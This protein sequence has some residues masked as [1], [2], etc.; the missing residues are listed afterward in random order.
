MNSKTTKSVTGNIITGVLVLGVITLG[1][2]T[3]KQDAAVPP[4]DTT[5]QG[6]DTALSDTSSAPL[7]TSLRVAQTAKDLRDLSTSVANSSSLFNRPVFRSLKDFSV[8]ISSEPAGRENPFVKTSWRLKFEEL[9]RAAE[10]KASQQASVVTAVSAPAAAPA[11][12]S[13][14]TFATSTPAENT[15]GI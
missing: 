1:Y 15:Q 5:I 14:P 8:G 3:F 12:T 4:T 10:K 13:V 2:F 9:E 6:G 7:A 11:P